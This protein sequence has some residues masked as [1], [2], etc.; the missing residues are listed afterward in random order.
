MKVVDALDEGEMLS[1]AGYHASWY[2][3]KNNVNFMFL[4]PISL[5][6]QNLQP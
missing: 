6:R 2:K 4:Q 3:H 5:K 1:W